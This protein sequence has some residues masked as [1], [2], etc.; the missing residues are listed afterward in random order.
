M[1]DFPRKAGEWTELSRDLVYENPWIEVL[2]SKMLN[3]NGGDGIYGK[4]HFKNLAI[5]I[6]AVTEEDE[7]FLVGQER[8]PFDGAYSWEIIE[9]GGPLADD[10]LESAKRELKE[11]TGLEAGS[12]ER[13][14][15]M[16]LSNS[17]SDEVSIC[18]LARDLVQKEAEPEDSEKLQI[19]K[20]PF[21]EALLMAL[22][23][24]IKDSISVAALLRYALFKK[25]V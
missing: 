9:G 7:V 16:H 19:K 23:G 17:V 4:V 8:Y 14:Q 1:T 11:E 20:L 2:H 13:I 6:L 12:W 10:P 15:E 25:G 21:Q 5:G 24:E 3:P 18:Y 22:N